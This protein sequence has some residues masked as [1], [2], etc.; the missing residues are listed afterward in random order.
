L[1]IW[2]IASKEKG[3]KMNVNVRGGRRTLLALAFLAPIVVAGLSENVMRFVRATCGYGGCCESDVDDCVDFLPMEYT[4]SSSFRRFIDFDAKPDNYPGLLPVECE[5]PEEEKELSWFWA[6]WD[7]SC[8]QNT[9]FGYGWGAYE[10]ALERLTP[11][12]GP[13]DENKTLGAKWEILEVEV[14]WVGWDTML[15]CGCAVECGGEKPCEARSFWILPHGDMLIETGNIAQRAT[16]GGSPSPPNTRRRRFWQIDDS[17][18]VGQTTGDSVGSHS[19][20]V[21][22]EFDECP[23]TEEHK[24][25]VNQV[26][27]MMQ[28]HKVQTMWYVSDDEI[29]REGVTLDFNYAYQDAHI[30][31]E[32]VS[33]E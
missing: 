11:F 9:Q 1:K 18:V 15:L 3:F 30:T 32:M 22:A 20:L 14:N 25:N 12:S 26:F 24:A 2:K 27:S 28:M 17:C 16:C 23:C 13:T 19:L 33:A 7:E 21:K 6:I 10:P 31:N 8:T 29:Y 5:D 4:H